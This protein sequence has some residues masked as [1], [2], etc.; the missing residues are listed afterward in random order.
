MRLIV[1][2]I[3]HLRRWIARYNVALNYADDRERRSPASE[4]EWNGAMIEDLKRR[5]AD[6]P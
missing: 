4:I 5:S 1:G 6:A 3:Q 2:L